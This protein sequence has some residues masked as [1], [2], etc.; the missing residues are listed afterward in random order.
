MKK[1]FIPLFMTLIIYFISS[2]AYHAIEIEDPTIIN[3]GK[4]I[5]S[6][7]TESI[8]DKSLDQYLENEPKET[9]QQ[10]E[11]RNEWEAINDNHEYDEYDMQDY[12]GE[13]DD[14]GV[15]ENE[16]YFNPYWGDE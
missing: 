12:G 3:D 1:A 15:D 6:K 2:P 9:L 14:D 13:G 10:E 16:D 4:A 5:N 8:N 11:K 7:Q